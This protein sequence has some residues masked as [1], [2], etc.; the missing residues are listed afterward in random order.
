[1]S[2]LPAAILVLGLPVALVAVVDR[3][4]ETDRPGP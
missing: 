1:M 3:L 4:G 2:R